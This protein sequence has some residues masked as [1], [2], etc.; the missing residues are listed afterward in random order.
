[1]RQCRHYDRVISSVY[2]HCPNRMRLLVILWS[3][4][5]VGRES[6]VVRKAARRTY[7]KVRCVVGV[8]LKRNVEE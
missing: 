8:C 7:L 5:S 3:F 1:M 2:F 4:A 6:E